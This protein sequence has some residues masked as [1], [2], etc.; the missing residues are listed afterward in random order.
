MARKGLLIVGVGAAALLMMPKPKKKKK[1]A[2][3]ASDPNIVQTGKHDGWSWRI[4]KSH[5]AGFAAL[6]AAE[7]N[8]P[9]SDSWVVVNVEGT[10]KKEHARLIAL[11]AI[12]KA[13]AGKD[14]DQKNGGPLIVDAGSANGWAWRVRTLPGDP[15][16]GDLFFGEIQAP[17]SDEWIAAHTDGAQSKVNAKALALEK[18]ALDTKKEGPSMGG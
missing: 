1:S 12:A 4:R 17:D 11:E 7:I 18:I 2:K 8:A 3:K 13:I 16:F 15:G 14:E 6:Y 10:S 5:M 9:D